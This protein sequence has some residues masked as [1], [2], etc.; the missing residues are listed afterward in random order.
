ML[1]FLPPCFV[2]SPDV[3]EL[4][5]AFHFGL[6]WAS[7]YLTC[8]RMPCCTVKTVKSNTENI[9]VVVI[10][11]SSGW[12]DCAKVQMGKSQPASPHQE[13]SGAE[14]SSSWCHQHFPTPWGGALFQILA[15]LFNSES[16][17][18]ALTPLFHLLLPFCHSWVQHSFHPFAPKHLLLD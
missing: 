17:K 6:R 4:L 12:K 10:L 2:N 1:S 15:F 11:H 14:S 5:L 13:T 16:I 7:C 3:C 9:L 18:T 8:C